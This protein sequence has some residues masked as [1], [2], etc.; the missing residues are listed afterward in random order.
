MDNLNTITDK[1]AKAVSD[2]SNNLVAVQS[3]LYNEEL[4]KQ[5]Q[6]AFILE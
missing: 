4:S 1:K 5:N 2:L 6:Y 3:Q